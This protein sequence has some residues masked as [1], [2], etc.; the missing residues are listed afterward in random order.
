MLAYADKRIKNEFLLSPPQITHGA[1]KG[2][3]K[4]RTYMRQAAEEVK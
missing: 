4:Y 1:V 3:E 2:H